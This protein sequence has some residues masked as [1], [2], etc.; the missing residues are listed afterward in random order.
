[1]TNEGFTIPYLYFKQYLLTVSYD[2][3]Y[4]LKTAIIDFAYNHPWQFDKGLHYQ[5]FIEETDALWNS[6]V[7][8][9]SLQELIKYIKLTLRITT[10]GF[11][12]L[13]AIVHWTKFW[14]IAPKNPFSEAKLKSKCCKLH[15]Y[16]IISKQYKYIISA[17]NYTLINNSI[18][19]GT[20]SISHKM[21][22][23][24]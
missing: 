21:R 17:L 9:N 2:Y 13:L 15:K 19:F 23:N 10:C 4:T 22:N 14:I 7:I 3:T 1:M 8:P 12:S 18:S 24:F 11:I 6:K 5:G 20:S 16:V